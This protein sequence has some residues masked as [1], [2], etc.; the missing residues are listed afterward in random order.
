MKLL[1]ILIP[2]Y[3]SQDYLEHCIE[4][5]LP[6]AGRVEII[7]I[8]DGST[9]HTPQMADRFAADHP[10]TI[11]VI[12][13]E[14][15]GH[16]GALNAGI[17]A[18]SGRYIKVLDSDDWVD[19]EAYQSLL[20]TLE[21][22]ETERTYV[23]MLLTNFVYEKQGAAHKKVISYR[24][25]IPVNQIFTWKDVKKFGLT[26]YFIMHAIVYRTK[27]LRDCGL[28]LPEHTFY[29][30][31]LFSYVPLPYVKRMYYLDV[32]LYRYFIGRDDQSVN[33]SVM[34]RRIDQQ[35]YVNRLLIAAHDPW[36]IKNP[37]LRAYM[38]N[39]I[40][41]ITMVTTVLLI[42]SGTDEHIRK[43]RML[44]REIKVKYPRLHSWLVRHFPGW[45]FNLPK[46]M[47]NLFVVVVY[48][49]FQKIW[50]FN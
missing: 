14:N 31:N 26:H 39:F 1:S 19:D 13:Q 33:E 3:N 35:I 21:R 7:I 29:E 6:G 47:G 25:L 42:R 37:H 10:E 5:L 40:N 46:R 32:D 27:M 4:T 8:N 38:L 15:K 44:W 28:K 45:V 22:F 30:D 17:A 12:H 2:C 20:D 16:G 49:L 11:R 50:G 24:D 41:I 43:K 9:D 34:I 18:A 23:D 48:T 36:K